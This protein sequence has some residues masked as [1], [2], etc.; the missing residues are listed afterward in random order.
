[1][2]NQGIRHLRAASTLDKPVGLPYRERSPT[3]SERLFR[4]ARR[5]SRMVRILRRIIPTAIVV[6]LAAIVAVA[7][8]NPFRTLAN[9][10]VD[11]GKLVVSGTKITMEAPRLAGYTRDSRPYELTASA[12][13]Q[14]IT[15]PG[16][17]ELKDIRAK[18]QMR[19]SGLLQL[20]AAS[21]VYDTKGDVMHL[22][23][24]IVLSSSGGYTGRLEDAIVDIKKGRITSD[25]PVKVEML[26]GTLD[27]KNLVVSESGDVVT[28]GGGVVMDMTL[29]EPSSDKSAQ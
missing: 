16:V 27:A 23:E 21:G 9:L 29:N 14:D 4:R 19:D 18:V 2:Q 13:A 25:R 5:H 20:E 17:L 11:P 6:G 8:L 26:N 28:F 1:L 22:K 7:Y 24:H 15:N 12:A 3:D 10:P